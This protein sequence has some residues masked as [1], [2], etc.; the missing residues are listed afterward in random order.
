MKS[1]VKLD[2]DRLAIYHEGRKR[3]I[4][5][6]ELS[7]DREFDCYELLYDQSYASSKKAIPIGPDL[8]LFQLRHRSMPGKLFA[9][10]IDRLPVK[11]NPAYK[12][13]CQSQGISVD[14]SNLILLLKTIGRRGPSSFVFEAVYIEGFSAKDVIKMR[15]QLHITQHDFSEA[16]DINP[17]TLRRLELGVSSDHNTLKRIEVF[18]TFPEVA[19]WQLKLTGCKV[20]KDIYATLVD[21]FTCH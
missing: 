4:F 2:V 1:F 10:F 9:S 14:E 13:Y 20:H 11:D 19:L 5:V 7:Y 17:Q 16:F 6:G 8:N 21:Y 18:F 3:R 12:D 15:E